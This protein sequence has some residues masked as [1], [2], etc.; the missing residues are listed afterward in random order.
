MTAI[1]YRNGVMAA[2][3]ACNIAGI[4]IHVPKVMKVRGHLIGVCGNNTPPDEYLLKWF[5][6]TAAGEN[7]TPIPTF[8]FDAM[9]VTPKAKIQV[10]DQR[11]VYEPISAPFFAVGSGS[12][13]CMGAMEMGA[14]AVQAVRAAIKWGPAIRGQVISRRL[15]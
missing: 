13:F 15:K 6:A 3:T 11:G 7:K 14:T 5:F 10:W 12:D 1:A 8:E 4:L 2:D 9:V